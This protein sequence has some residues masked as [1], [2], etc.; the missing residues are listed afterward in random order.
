MSEIVDIDS[1]V[2]LKLFEDGAI[3]I[4]L[5][6]PEGTEFGIDMKVWNT[7]EKFKGIKMIPPGLHFI[8]YSPV[9]VCGESGSRSGFFY[10]FRKREFLVKKWDR[11]K[12]D[13]NFNDNVPDEL[14][15]RLKNN[16]L[17]VDK[18]LGPYPFTEYNKWLRLTDHLNGMFICNFSFRIIK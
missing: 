13:I 18:N 8:H 3:F 12:E 2:A 14:I 16:V 9:D 10:N 15:Q 4:L 11:E 5:D 7:A 6:V 17:N 1:Q